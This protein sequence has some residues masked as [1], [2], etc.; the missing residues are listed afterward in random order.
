MRP[1]PMI[2]MGSWCPQAKDT[3]PCRRAAKIPASLVG[4]QLPPGRVVPHGAT[5]ES[6]RALILGLMACDESPSA[7]SRRTPNAA[8]CC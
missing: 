3:S 8:A 5:L 1:P 2:Q 6:L 4:A 7:A